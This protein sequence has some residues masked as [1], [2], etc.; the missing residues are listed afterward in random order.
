MTT[1]RGVD[2]TT[3]HDRALSPNQITDA[4]R[5]FY[6]GDGKSALAAHFGVTDGVIAGLLAR[7]GVCRKTV[8]GREDSTFDARESAAFAQG[9]TSG[10][11]VEKAGAALGKTIA[12]SRSHARVL[13][14][15]NSPPR[16]SSPP[17]KV[18]ISERSASLSL[19]AHYDGDDRL[20][21]AL[22]A[23]GGFHRYDDGLDWLLDMHGAPIAAVSDHAKG[24]LDHARSLTPAQAK[25]TVAGVRVVAGGKAA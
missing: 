22:L 10:L 15:I 18:D 11:G 14:L 4:V 23:E 1:S 9:V 20:V 3:T 5:R 2:M 19:A 7:G 21:A 6:A 24:L 25:A 16:K 12:A 8:E 13:G 17:P